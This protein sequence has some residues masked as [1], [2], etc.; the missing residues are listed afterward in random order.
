MEIHL[1]NGFLY[2]IGIAY[3]YIAEPKR[4]QTKLNVFVFSL[5]PFEGIHL[6]FNSILLT[7]AQI[8]MYF[9]EVGSITP[10]KKKFFIETKSC[11][12]QIAYNFV[13]SNGFIM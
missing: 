9:I 11:I 8:E 13:G 7:I 10:T 3:I 6:I 5:A 4:I 2:V 1:Q 12:V